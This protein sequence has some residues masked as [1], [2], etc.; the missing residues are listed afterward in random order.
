MPEPE[1]FQAAREASAAFEALRLPDAAARR[2]RARLDAPG[3]PRWLVSVAL[4]AAAA[5][6]AALVVFP[7]AHEEERTRVTASRF[8]SY[9]QLPGALVLR[10]GS[11]EVDTSGSYGIEVA[12]GRVEVLGA[13]VTVSIDD[14][15]GSVTLHEGSA[16]FRASDGREVRLAPDRTLE[17]PLPE[18]APVEGRREE[19]PAEVEAPVRP[20]RPRAPR[21]ITPP[22]ALPSSEALLEE[23]ARLRSRGRYDEAV[24][25]LLEAL[26]EE[27]H[28]STRERLSFEL[29]A[30][31]ST[32]LQDPVRA[33]AHWR[34]HAR[35]FPS[36]RYEEEVSVARRQLGCE[37]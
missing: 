8:A 25:R 6:A 17:L 7:L 15:T 14:D 24:A 26:R 23:L 19:P 34:S 4:V 11:V 20:P 33:C 10:S 16:A 3:A 32:Q 35:E 9:Q 1:L 27:R 21:V 22:P 31:L 36:G 37:P 30:I 5:A 28:P 12:W 29:S 2:I 13:R 18:P